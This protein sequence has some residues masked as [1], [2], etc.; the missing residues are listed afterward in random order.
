MENTKGMVIEI[1]AQ[2]IVLLTSDGQFLEVPRPTGEVHCGQEIE[3]S[4][5]QKKRFFMPASLMAAAAAVLILFMFISDFTGYTPFKE[6]P[7]YGYIAMDINPSVELAFNSELEITEVRGINPEGRILLEGL[8]QGDDL[9][10]SLEYLLQRA[11]EMSYLTPDHAQN[12]LMLTL[13]NPYGFSVSEAQLENLVQQNLSERNIP[14]FVGIYKTGMDARGKAL[15]QKISLNRF[16]LQEAL[17]DRGAAA[18]KI[19]ADIPLWE[20]FKETDGF[21]PEPFNPVE[22]RPERIEPDPP[23]PSV[24]LPGEKP[25][26]DKMPP[27]VQ[28]E[29]E[30]EGPPP[31]VPELKPDE[32]A[33]EIEGVPPVEI[34]VRMRD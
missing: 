14:G 7:A 11:V 5:P 9:F 10:T 25:P 24:E 27:E 4:L 16:L 6:D 2:K 1:K 15:G 31:P 19:P 33:E 17:K 29:G 32:E 22:I 34:P 21:L 30:Q 12:F 28:E 3:Y 13:V 26:V 20:I 8:N 23:T 18:Q